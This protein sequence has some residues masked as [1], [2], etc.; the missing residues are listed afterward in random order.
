MPAA[1][2]GTPC[3]LTAWLSERGRGV[4]VLSDEAWGAVSPVIP[5]RFSGRNPRRALDGVLHK[6]RSGCRWNQLPREYGHYRAVQGQLHRWRRS[7]AMEEVL[8]ALAN[9]PS[10]PLVV[11]D[12]PPPLKLTGTLIPELFLGLDPHSAESSRKRQY[13]QRG[14]RFSLPEAD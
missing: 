3:T 9:F 6:V 5:V 8:E 12:L 7:G 4:P 1:R 13:P 11:E 10:T 2:R 14:F